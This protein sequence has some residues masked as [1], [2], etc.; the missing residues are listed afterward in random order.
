M[1]KQ[2]MGT[3]AGFSWMFLICI[4]LLSVSVLVFRRD[5]SPGAFGTIIVASEATIVAV[6]IGGQL[7]RKRW[8]RW[9]GAACL[10]TL[11]VKSALRS[12]LLVG[13][14]LLSDERIL[15]PVVSIVAAVFI[16]LAPR[17]TKDRSLDGAPN[18]AIPAGRDPRER[19]SRP[20][21]SKSLGHFGCTVTV[22]VLY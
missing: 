3:L 7:A 16:A 14:N 15:F 1:L 11:A 4:F 10:V 18:L 19:G 13:P 21:S 2:V 8:A 9:V 6:A 17:K 20:L 12:S 5:E 22:K